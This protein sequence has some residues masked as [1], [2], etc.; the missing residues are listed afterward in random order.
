MSFLAALHA[1]LALFAS[2]PAPAETLSYGADPLQIVR[3]FRP[4]GDGPHPVAVT[5]LH[6]CYDST[7]TWD[8]AFPG[9]VETWTARGF[10]VWAIGGRCNRRAAYSY[11]DF[12]AGRA[13]LERHADRLGLDTSQVIL[14][15]ED[16]ED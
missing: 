7:G 8:D 9:L 1:P 14:L 10:A 12:M 5:H 15:G 2:D 4:S 6:I 3:V 11:P 13:L 16:A